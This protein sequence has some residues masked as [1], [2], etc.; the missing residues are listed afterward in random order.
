MKTC[1]YCEHYKS[2][3]CLLVRIQKNAF[4]SCD[5]FMRKKKKVKNIWEI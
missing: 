4:E 2:K 1:Q 3:Q 5:K